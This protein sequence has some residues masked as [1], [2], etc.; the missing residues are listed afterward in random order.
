MKKRKEKSLNAAWA[1]LNRAYR[2]IHVSEAQFACIPRKT[3][4][5]RVKAY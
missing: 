1:F 5:A 3:N 2:Q 4:Q